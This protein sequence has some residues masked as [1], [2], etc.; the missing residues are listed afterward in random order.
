[1]TRNPRTPER[2]TEACPYGAERSPS[3]DAP[4]VASSYTPEFREEAVR[5]GRDPRRHQAQVL[6]HDLTGRERPVGPRPHQPG[7]HRRGAGSAVGG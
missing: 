3:D 4:K 1:V 2:W 6:P 7:L 5:Q